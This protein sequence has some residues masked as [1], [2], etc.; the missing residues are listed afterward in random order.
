MNIP[1]LIAV[2]AAPYAAY[3]FMKSVA[4]PL[5]EQASG[6]QYPKPRLA[7]YHLSFACLLVGTLLMIF[8]G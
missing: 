4:H 8:G 5:A 6:R 1:A 7:L 2:L 3:F